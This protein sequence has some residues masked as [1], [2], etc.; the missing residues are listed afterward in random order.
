[1]CIR[2]RARTTCPSVLIET[3]F[4]SNNA[5]SRLLASDSFQN[6]IS[7][8]IVNSINEFVGFS[9][10]EPPKAESVTTPEEITSSAC[11]TVNA[12]NVSD[13]GS[14]VKEVKAAVSVS[15]THLS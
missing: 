15:Y 12:N 9:D 8:R 11:F 6:N 5:E 4:I 1:M 10:K 2:D 3:G 14:G 13:S 7:S